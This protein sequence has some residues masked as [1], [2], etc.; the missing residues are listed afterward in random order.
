MK[1]STPSNF[2]LRNRFILSV[3]HS[4]CVIFRVFLLHVKP[5]KH[6]NA[7][8]NLSK[9][10]YIY[11]KIKLNVVLNTKGSLIQKRTRNV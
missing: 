11:L 9:C 4:D 1:I 6:F 10:L 8:I 7:R 5:Q 3:M 2:I